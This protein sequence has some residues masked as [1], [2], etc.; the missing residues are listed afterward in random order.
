M[1]TSI[2]TCLRVRVKDGILK[3]WTVKWIGRQKFS[4]GY[5]E[6][7]KQRI[8]FW[9]H[10]MFVDIFAVSFNISSLANLIVT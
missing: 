6:K 8:F 4:F 2:A 3:I 5:F 9:V 1:L 7:E 10:G